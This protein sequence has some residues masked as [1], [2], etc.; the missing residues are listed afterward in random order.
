MPESMDMTK[1]VPPGV[2]RDNKPS[3]A[4]SVE[5]ER[6]KRHVRPVWIVLI[7]LLPCLALTFLLCADGH[8]SG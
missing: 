8:S 5:S 1:L 4:A 6:R 2:L 7:L 3:S